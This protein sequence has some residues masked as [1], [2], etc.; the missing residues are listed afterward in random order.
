MNVVSYSVDIDL[1]QQKKTIS[2]L[3]LQSGDSSVLN[4]SL[5]Y[6]VLCVFAMQ[7]LQ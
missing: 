7:G 3:D 5:K 1:K 2:W 4:F 6:T